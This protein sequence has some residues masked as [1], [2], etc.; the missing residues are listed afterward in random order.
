VLQVRSFANLIRER[1]YKMR[2]VGVGGISRA[3]D[4]RD[5]LAAGAESVQLATAAMVD[6]LIGLAIRREISGAPQK[7]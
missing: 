7:R 4:V 3:A 5:Y 6:P 2:L 1:N